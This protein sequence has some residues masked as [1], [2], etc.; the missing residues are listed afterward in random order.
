MCLFF[1]MFNHLGM[2]RLNEFIWRSVRLRVVT[3]RYDG[4]WKFQEHCQKV[5]H[6]Q[7]VIYN[8]IHKSNDSV[9]FLDDEERTDHRGS[10][11][12]HKKIQCTRIATRSVQE[13]RKKHTM[14]RNH[15]LR[16]TEICFNTKTCQI[17][18]MNVRRLTRWSFNYCFVPCPPHST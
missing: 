15:D 11:R 12:L 14:P 3:K 17:R 2:S 9:Y 8:G 18:V 7:R 6:H 10:L 4:P 13:L 5:I 16:R 1:L